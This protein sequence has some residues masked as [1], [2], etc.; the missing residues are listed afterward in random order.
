VNIL[1]DNID[2]VK[3]NTETWIDAS[4]DISL[5]INT[6]RTKYMLVSQHENANQNRDKNNKHIVWKNMYITVHNNWQWQ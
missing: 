2:T 4:E 6:G 1:G 3:K 5:E